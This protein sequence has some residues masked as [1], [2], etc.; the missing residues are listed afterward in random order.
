[1]DNLFVKLGDPGRVQVI[2]FFLLACSLF[3]VAP[4]AVVGVFFGYSPAH[5]C[6]A[7][8]EW[9]NVTETPDTPR[10]VSLTQLN[11]SLPST[12]RS[13]QGQFEF[14]YLDDPATLVLVSL[15][16]QSAAEN[17]ESSRPSQAGDRNKSDGG[18]LALGIIQHGN[19]LVNL[20]FN[21]STFGQQAQ[22]TTIST[23]CK[24]GEWVYDLSGREASTV[25]D[26][27]NQL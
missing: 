3:T 4:N 22:K 10:I 11:S 1:M 9:S 26:V 27:S 19:C 18:A 20:T 24:R 16:R 8:I 25:T 17:V 14:D 15:W 2:W 6:N 23:A 7:T 12:F 5:F 21:A 13:A